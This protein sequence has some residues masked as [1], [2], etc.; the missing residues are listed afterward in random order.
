MSFPVVWILAHELGKNGNTRD[1]IERYAGLLNVQARADID[2][3]SIRLGRLRHIRLASSKGWQWS[4][5]AVEGE[6]PSGMDRNVDL[7]CVVEARRE[8]D[9]VLSINGTGMRAAIRTC[10]R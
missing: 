8:S 7:D 5:S 3:V 6:G 4:I 2:V 1:G 9:S 10:T